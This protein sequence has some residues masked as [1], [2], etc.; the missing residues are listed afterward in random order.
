MAAGFLVQL[1]GKLNYPADNRVGAR[2][3]QRDSRAH[4]LG[5]IGRTTSRQAQGHANPELS[6]GG[7][8]RACLS[9]RPAFPAGFQ[10][11]CFL[12][13][14]EL[15]RLT[16]DPDGAASLPGSKA[17]ALDDQAGRHQADDDLTPRS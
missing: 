2:K 3:H 16:L 8:L 5:D 14:P 6:H 4:L 7:D 17:L 15:G 13:A 11:F 9:T 12:A 1:A 10:G